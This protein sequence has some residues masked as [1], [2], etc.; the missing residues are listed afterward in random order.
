M[1]KTFTLFATLAL[2][3]A[4]FA[5]DYVFTDQQG[6]VLEDGAT[7]DRT[8]VEDDGFGGSMI[9]GKLFVKNNADANGKQVA[10]VT[11]VSRIDNGALQLCFPVNCETYNEAGTYETVEKGTLALGEQ[12]DL[13]TEWLPE[14]DGQ[15]I[16]TYK[17]KTYQSLASTVVRTINVKYKQ[18]NS[19]TQLWWGYV[20]D[21]NGSGLGTNTAETYHCAIFI[22]GNH[23][24]AAGKSICSIRFGL[25]A[26]SATN[27]KVWVAKNLPTTPTTSNTLA[28]ESVPSE[29]L[30]SASIS[31]KLTNPVEIAAAGVYVGYSFTIG[32]TST[33]ADQYPIL[34]TGDPAPNTLILRT[35]QTMTSWSDMNDFGRLCL[36]ALL[37]GEFADNTATAADFGAA[38]ALLGSSAT[39]K[40]TVTNG[41]A[42]PVSSIDYTITTDGVASAEQHADLDSPIAFNN[43][44]K[45]TIDIPA[46]D[47]PGLKA[48]T[49]NITKVNGHANPNADNPANFSLYTLSKLI[50]RNAVVEQYTG[51]GCGW[52]PRGH[53]GMEKMRK[54]FGERFIGIAIHQYSPQSQ[55]AMYIAPAL[56]AKHGLTGAP[57]CR[58]NRG[59]SADPYYGYGVDILDDFRAEMEL[60]A[61]AEV[62]VRGTL[63]VEKT[64]VE[65]KAKTTALFDGTYKLEFVL[66]ADSLKGTGAGWN[67]A[68]FYSSAYASQ[69]GVTKASLPSDLKYLYDLG[70]TFN[71]YF[72]DVAI[73]SSYTSSKNQV[74]DLTLTAGTEAQTTYTLKMP[75]YTKLKNAIKE[76]NLYVVA[77]LIDS[78]GNIVN[79][80]KRQVAIADPAGIEGVETTSDNQPAARY[81]LDGRRVK[82]MQ[83]G[84]NIIRMANG[85]AIKVIGK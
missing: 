3:S 53:V 20:D 61:L 48:K 57:S 2:A 58:I 23:A 7:I 42:T 66:V 24:V 81:T 17:I 73:A 56:Y 31:V 77:L 79:A 38:Y 13:Q 68:N 12:K 64:Q 16:V 55:D 32:K 5:Q 59:A 65:A 19:N 75:T 46:D 72:N 18:G 74:E 15:C 84:L 85:K 51:T 9:P 34:I 52:C 39:A 4:T 26:S 78:Q 29:K 1:K 47:E 83:K 11:E 36:Q 54:N 71:P 41:G 45:V 70:S 6:N 62:S 60:P 33:Q 8:E 35:S 37:E 22:P 40:L 28:L 27:V 43:S 69:T 82:T 49:L 63:N 76:D 44:G 67:Q 21:M 10:I 25:T 30:G 50:D 14:D 80:A